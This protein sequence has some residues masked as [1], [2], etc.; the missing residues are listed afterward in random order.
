MDENQVLDTINAVEP[1][2]QQ[3]TLTQDQVNKIVAREKAKA[4]ESATRAAEEKYQRDLES[5][6]AMRQ[7]QQQRNA[8][9]PR[10]FDANAMYQQFTERLNKEMHER[11]VKEHMTQ[12]AN[13][14]QQKIGLGKHSYADFEDVTKDFDPTAFPQLTY[15]LAGIDN[16]ADVLYDLSKNPLKLAGLDR[17]AEKNPRQAQSEMLKLAQ[18]IAANKQAQSESQNQNVAEPLD[19]LAPS[20]VSGNNGKLSIRDLRN[21]PWLRNA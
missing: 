15:L 10:D 20:R 13:T 5:L 4:A 9:V 18:S 17:L 8:E 14:Y 6:N 2:Q 7:Q 3:N 16:A 21:Q 12:I 19:R 11:Q 1:S